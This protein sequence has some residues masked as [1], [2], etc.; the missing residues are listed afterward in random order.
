MSEIIRL[1]DRFIGAEIESIASEARLMAFNDGSPVRIEHLLA[2]H[3][4]IRPLSRRMQVQFAAMESWCQ[5][6]ATPAN[7][8]EAAAT[9][10]TAPVSRHR[11]RTLIN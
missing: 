3:A 5:E 11:R 4:N 9:V 10:P 7:R 1:T 6:N 8:A 2:A